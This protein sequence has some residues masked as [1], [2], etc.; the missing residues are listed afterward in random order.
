MTDIIKLMPFSEE[1][2]SQTYEWIC[3]PGLRR[4]FLMRGDLSWDGHVSHCN[5][6]MS[7]STQVMYAILF[8][9]KY[10]GN[11]GLKN[12]IKNTEGELWM[13]LGASDSRGK[14]VGTLVAKR[15]IEKIFC[16]FHLQIVYLHVAEFNTIAITMYRKLGFVEVPVKG[17]DDVW[18]DRNCK[19]IR[20]EQKRR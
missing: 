7:D 9:D 20:M 14:G 13:Y 11:C 18:L 10:I 1:Y 17:N 4:M 19:I 8:D 15:L 16:Q 6:V 2:V 3:E 12:I 5:R